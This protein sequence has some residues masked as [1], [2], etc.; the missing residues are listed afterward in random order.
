MQ[1]VHHVLVGDLLYPFTSDSVTTMA[2]IDDDIADALGLSNRGRKAIKAAKQRQAARTAKALQ[3]SLFGTATEPTVQQ[4]PCLQTLSKHFNPRT[5]VPRAM[6][7]ENV[8]APSWFP[9]EPT[10][11]IA[12]NVGEAVCN[13]LQSLKIPEGR[14][15]GTDL[16]LAPFQRDFVLGGLA[17]NIRNAVLSVGRG[18][19]KSA[20]AAG[21]ALA[22]LLGISDRQPRRD[23]IIAART[24]E[25]ARNLWAFAQ[26]FCSTLPEVV[27]AQLAFVRAPA[28]K[29][30]TRAM[31]DRT[32]FASPLQTANLLWDLVLRL[33]FWTSAAI[34]NRSKARNS[35]PRF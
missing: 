6:L 27:Q 2:A 16:K 29:S 5:P 3:P 17:P 4:P 33:S 32:R 8:F 10:D 12:D 18:N 34:G 35:K 14:N 19:A 7:P 1:A 30:V 23:V 28:M 13:F 26:A 11:P 9:R 20:L 21:V 25:Q 15:A 31:A 24:K 22:H